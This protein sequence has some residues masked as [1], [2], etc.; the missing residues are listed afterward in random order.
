MRVLSESGWGTSGGG[1]LIAGKSA[2]DGEPTA[3]V[4]CM[5]L[6]IW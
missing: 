6:L 4:V 5:D 1:S 3:V 2:P